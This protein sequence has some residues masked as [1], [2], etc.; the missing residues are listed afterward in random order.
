MIKKFSNYNEDLNNEDLTR[1]QKIDAIIEFTTK[2]ENSIDADRDDLSNLNDEM[3]DQFYNN[4]FGEQTNEGVTV[5]SPGSGTAVGGGSQ[6]SFVSSMGVSV[7][8]GDSGSAFSTN[9]SVSGM[10]AIVSPQPSQ[11]PGDVRGSTKGSGDIGSRGGTYTKQSAGKKKKTKRSKIASDIDKLYTTNYKE[12]SNNGKIIQSWNT[13]NENKEYN[14]EDLSYLIGEKINLIHTERNGVY[15]GS[16]SRR[17]KFDGKDVEIHGLITS[18]CEYRGYPSKGI[19]VRYKN[20]ENKDRLLFLK[21]DKREDLFYNGDSFVGS[22]ATD[23]FIGL[24]EKDNEILN[25]LKEYTIKD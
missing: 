15:L 11:T 25:S 3:L 6:G 18:V 9:S 2:D 10:G 16:Y 14:C 8:G 22:G 1:A 24:T 5:S 19:S 21:Y 13:F 20:S 23:T 7:N 12:S 17:D 4:L